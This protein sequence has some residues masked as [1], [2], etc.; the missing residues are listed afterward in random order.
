MTMM[1]MVYPVPGKRVRTPEGRLI[2][3][4]GLDVPWNIYY[5]RRL[6][7]G[8]ITLEPPTAAAPAAPAAPVAATVAPAA[9]AVAVP[10]PTLDASAAEQETAS[11]PAVN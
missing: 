8:D 2:P 3:A 6:N 11:S 5:V 10:T 9:A 7:Q 4:A 1:K